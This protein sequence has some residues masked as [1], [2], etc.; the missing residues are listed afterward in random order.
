[1]CPGFHPHVPFSSPFF[2]PSAPWSPCG[3]KQSAKFPASYR[4]IE[5]NKNKRL[6]SDYK[7]ILSLHH[8]AREGRLLRKG[9]PVKKE[10]SDGS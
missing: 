6:G 9:I 2:A 1:L 8:S 7:K 10:G 5:I 3:E 4:Y